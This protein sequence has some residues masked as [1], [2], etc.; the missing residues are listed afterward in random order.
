[1]VPSIRN[2]PK[3]TPDLRIVFSG[4]DAVIK[5]GV[6]CMPKKLPTITLFNFAYNAKFRLYKH[7]WKIHLKHSSN[8]I[9][10]NSKFPN[11]SEN[12]FPKN[13]NQLPHFFFFLFANPTSN[14]SIFC[15]LWPFTYATHLRKSLPCREYPEF[16]RKNVSRRRSDE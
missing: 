4:P 12:S 3:F 13:T 9:F 1:L 5:S 10:A 2:L 6:D 16:G 15:K 7:T 8:P 14:P 11:H